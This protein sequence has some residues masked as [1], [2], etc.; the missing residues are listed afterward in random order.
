MTCPFLCK[1]A[2]VLAATVS[3]IGTSQAEQPPETVHFRSA[4][5]K[6][7]LTGYV[8]APAVR[9]AA[10]VPAVVMM[11]GRA[12]PYSLNVKETG[13]YDATTLSRRHM[14]WGEIWASLGYIAVLV[15][16]FGPRGF[17]GGFG[18]HSI[19]ERPD[20]VNE[21]TVRPLDA[22]G[23][24]AWLRS[25]S[26]V[27]PDRIGLQ[28]WSN[29]GS[30]TLAAIAVDAP[31]IVEHNAAAGFRAALVFYA[32]CG[33][34][35]RY[36]EQ[37]YRPYT[38]V[39]EF[40]GTADEETGYGT[41][42][43]LVEKSHAAGGDIELVTYDNATHD[44]DDPGRNRQSVSANQDARSDAIARAQAFFERLLAQGLPPRR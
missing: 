25:R 24:L 8:F 20:E 18:R 14:Q 41:C 40:H 2:A 27:T 23:A 7:I 42:R 26:D 4:D 13:P 30:A 12:G 38:T 43:R 31:G 10:R 39:L 17:P 29:G 33:L 21:V 28:G 9:R 11:H 15:D 22:Y 34:R 1:L 5:G 36:K 19:N 37:S 6:T 44:F 3:M 35:E 32:G 16:G